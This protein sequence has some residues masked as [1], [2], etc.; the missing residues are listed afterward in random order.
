LAETG[1]GTMLGRVDL[2]AD[3]PAAGHRDFADPSAD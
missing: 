1:L 2:E 3:T